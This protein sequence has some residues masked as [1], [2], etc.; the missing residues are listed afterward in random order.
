MERMSDIIHSM[1]SR[2]WPS[3]RAAAVAFALVMIS[4]S[5]PATVCSQI[6]VDILTTPTATGAQ[7]TTTTSPTPT[8]ETSTTGATG[9]MQD[10]SADE[11]ARRIVPAPGTAMKST[12]DG[13]LQTGGAVATEPSLRIN[14]DEVVL[15]EGETTETVAV[16]SGV[17]LLRMLGVQ[18]ES[19][20]VPV[21]GLEMDET[22]SSILFDVSA[23]KRLKGDEPTVVY[24]VLVED[25]P[26]PD[27]MIVPWIRQA[28][29]LQERFDKAVRLL[30]ENMVIDGREE[31]LG[32][33]TDFP[34]SDHALQAKAILA[35]L[36]DMNKEEAPTPVIA[37]AEEETTVTVEL[38]PNISVGTVIV[39]PANTAGNRAMIGGKAY[40][41]GEEIRGQAGHRVIGISDSVVQVEVEQHGMKKTFDL[42]VRPSGANE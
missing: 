9:L 3:H 33:I 10:K 2:I 32:I 31:L 4:A 28:K 13:T 36:D 35:K 38:S 6:E 18:R 12:E 1:P 16:R 19:K 29:L 17:E 34:D 21:G 42:P 20:T 27:P 39:D 30:G 25:T 5:Q 24:R 41:V 8:P 40:R 7:T 22:T 11:A 37:T 23:V 26:L 15:K 14:Q